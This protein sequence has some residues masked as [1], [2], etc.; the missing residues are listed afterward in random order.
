MPDFLSSIPAAAA[1]PLALVAY[2]AVVAVWGA[3]ALKVK[4]SRDI[5]RDLEKLPG[6]DRLRALEAEIGHVHL[7]SGLTP[8]QWLRSR[9]YNYMFWGFIALCV[10][11]VIIVAISATVPSR[12]ASPSSGTGSLISEGVRLTSQAQC[13][14]LSAK[15]LGKYDIID[16]HNVYNHRF[17]NLANPPLGT[18]LLGSVP[19][20]LTKEEFR[21][22]HRFLQPYPVTQD[23]PINVAKP[24]N[25]HLVIDG[26]YAERIFRGRKVGEVKL[27]FANESSYVV[28][29]IV[30]ENVLE[31][32]SYKDE[33]FDIIP[34]QCC[35][36]FRLVWLEEHYRG[37]RP[38]Y[39][40]IFMMSI[41]V[42]GNLR[43]SSLTS[44]TINDLSEELV[45]SI[46]P[47]IGVRAITVEHD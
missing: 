43:S 31:S 25:V 40:Y 19:F 29:L 38:A 17:D 44:I 42:P 35:Y 32:W 1:S 16:L 5:L 26:G 27:L 47:S 8:E 2:L 21:T 12:N 18:C 34:P 9:I 36:W 22:Q 11:V 15:S 24:L 28:P 39:G 7:A 6:R 33:V 4:R 10:L 37:G 13:S 3:V 20:L 30:H 14:S 46:D 41:I 23:I 45:N